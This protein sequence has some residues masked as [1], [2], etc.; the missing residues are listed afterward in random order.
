MGEPAP[1]RLADLVDE[2]ARAHRRAVPAPRGL[3]YLGLDH[4]SGTPLRL[5]EDLAARGIFRKYELVLDVAAGLGA[6]SRWLALRLGCE[7]V[8]ATAADEAA[9]ADALGRR[10]RVGAHVRVVAAAPGALPA[11]DGRFTHVWAV[12]SLARVPDPAAALSEAWRA[13]R[14]GGT[15]AVQDLAPGGPDAPQIAG[16]RFASA[17]E[18][19][20]T[21]RRAGFVDVETR[22]RSDEASGRSAQVA[23]AR[24]RL[25]ER[26]RAD[27]IL[28]PLAAAREALAHALATGALRVVQMVGY[29]PTTRRA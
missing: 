17:D 13:L 12:E 24:A 8:A 29:R 20:A 11:R 7:V 9:G 21:L 28:A 15:I 4:A 3:P 18:R 25:V 14:P 26:L 10:A 6:T 5:L 23:A 16:W 1:A 22:D 19:L 2:L 27:A